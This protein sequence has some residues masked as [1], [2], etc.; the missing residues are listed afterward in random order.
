MNESN[1]RPEDYAHIACF[2]QT[3]EVPFNG[4]E[5]IQIAL[6]ESGAITVQADRTPLTFIRIRWNLSLP[7]DALTLGDAWER[8]YGDLEWR[9]LNAAH[10]MPWYF[11]LQTQTDI[12]GFGVKVRPG[13]FVGWTAD[14]MGVSCW[15]DLRNGG[16]GVRL[17]GRSLHA[18]DLVFSKYSG[19][20]PWQA[21][22]RF[23]HEMCT[24]PI[25]PKTPVYGSNNWYYAYGNITEAS[26]LEDCRLLADLTTGL[27][28]RPF[29]VIDDGW[30]V[31]RQEN[32]PN[33][34][35]WNRG[36][37]FF[38]SMDKI[39]EKMKA[40]GVRPGIW[41]RPLFL[42]SEIIPGGAYLRN[43]KWML[44]PSHPD[45]LARVSQDVSRF[46]DW[47]FELLKHD[48][49]TVDTTGNYGFA[50]RPWLC[51]GDW[52]FFDRSHTTAEI[53]RELYRTIRRAAG[54][55]LILGCNVAGHLAAGFQELSRTG[56]DTSG[57][58]WERTR[59]MGINT[60]AFRHAQHRTFFDMD[61]DCV[62]ISGKIPWYFN[63][64]WAKLIAASGSSLFL[65]PKPGV[66]S[67]QE[68][69]EVKELFRLA[70]Q[71]KIQAEPLDWMTNP[72]PAI[73][74]IAGEK[75]TLAL[76]DAS[77]DEP[78]FLP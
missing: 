78:D 54:D 32:Q 76:Y 30:Q 50:A 68:T 64:Q 26:V 15:L 1:F 19:I 52:G 71:G 62:G 18:A 16:K 45:V 61:A 24:D 49:S 9:H 43:E 37:E 40:Q 57:R 63:R 2:S 35:P 44:D 72:C 42:N 3:G 51:S 77:G 46:R 66:L 60:L 27:A 22:R 73:W 69:A 53:L 59:K 70:A 20:S 67:E 74:K 7:A 75:V 47:G 21:A 25:F 10:F 14:P 31:M 8:S 65:S 41:Y 36:N 6:S 38:P 58:R 11:L 4:N 39:A 55:M 48:F 17:N 12:Y 33:Y 56:D 13:A 23:C 28:D 29:M 34:G 5:E